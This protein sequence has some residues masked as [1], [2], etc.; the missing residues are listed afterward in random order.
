MTFS[1]NDTGIFWLGDSLQPTTQP[2]CTPRDEATEKYKMSVL[3]VMHL[4]QQQK[5]KTT[6]T[7]LDRQWYTAL[8]LFLSADTQYAPRECMNDASRA[9]SR[10]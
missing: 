9:P 3:F 2:P 4:R 1:F 8:L 10:R 6:H 5:V 7:L